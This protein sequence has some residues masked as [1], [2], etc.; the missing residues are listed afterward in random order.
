MND[1]ENYLIIK[2]ASKHVL[3]KVGIYSIGLLWSVHNEWK[4]VKVI[5]FYNN[6]ARHDIDN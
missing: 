3:W 1:A 5:P 2:F 4:H 6:G